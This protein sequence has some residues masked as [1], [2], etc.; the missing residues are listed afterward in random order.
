MGGFLR[1]VVELE[2]KLGDALQ[3][4]PFIKLCADIPGV[5]FKK[6]L[7]TLA[8]RVRTQDGIVNIEDFAVLRKFGSGQRKYAV[9]VNAVDIPERRIYLLEEQ[10]FKPFVSFFYHSC[11][12]V[13]ALTGL[14]GGLGARRRK[15]PYA[16]LCSYNLYKVAYAEV[17]EAF[18]QNAALNAFL[19]VLNVFLEAL[20]PDY[21]A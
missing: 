10:L 8:L 5:R 17:L 15:A 3:T 1:S 11:K 18:K 4:Q 12:P 21:L 13:T 9:G 6:K 16:L 20:E 7:L 14:R 19:H 2:N